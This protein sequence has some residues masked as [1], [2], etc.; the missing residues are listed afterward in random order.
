[1]LESVRIDQFV[2]DFAGRSNRRQSPHAYVDADNGVGLGH[3]GPLGAS[4]THPQRRNDALSLAR[5]RD[6]EDLGSV[7]GDK[8]FNPA[9]VLVRANGAQHRQSEMSPVGFEP[10]HPS[11]KGESVPVTS[12]LLESGKAD[13]AT[14]DLTRARLLPAPVGVARPAYAV[15]EDLLRDLW[16]P[17]LTGVSV[18]ADDVLVRVPAFAQAVER[19]GRPRLTGVVVV[20]KVASDPFKGPVERCA[21]GS[22]E[23]RNLSLLLDGG[24][25]GEGEGLNDVAVGGRV[26]TRHQTPPGPPPTP[27]PHG[28]RPLDDRRDGHRMTSD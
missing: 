7:K 13:L 3:A 27:W 11:S 12:A 5:D 18:H 8:P 2:D 6:A 16:P 24:I 4:D 26:P 25:E 28:A 21:A 17:D 23:P 10:H 1:M 20:L 22:K 15:G 14:L 9:G 19:R